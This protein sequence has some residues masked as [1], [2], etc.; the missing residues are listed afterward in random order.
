MNKEP[1]C[2]F[3]LCWTILLVFITSS[4]LWLFLVPTFP[5]FKF[6]KFQVP[7]LPLTSKFVTLYFQPEDWI[8]K[9]FQ[10]LTQSQLYKHLLLLILNLTH[11]LLQKGSVMMRMIPLHLL[12]LSQAMSQMVMTRWPLLWKFSMI[13]E[14]KSRPKKERFVCVQL[15]SVVWPSWPACKIQLL[16]FLLIVCAVLFCFFFSENAAM[17]V[18]TQAAQQAMQEQVSQKRAAAAVGALGQQARD[19]SQAPCSCN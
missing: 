14:H 15:S 4:S 3:S 6:Q 7:F 10:Q 9:H 1:P 8:R 19:A 2:K 17:A 16:L 5:I 12:T 18:A 13:R 11:C